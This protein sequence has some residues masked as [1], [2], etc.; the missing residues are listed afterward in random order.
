MA[1]M[2]MP[3][4]I[5]TKAGSLFN[6]IR[7]DFPEIVFE[8]SSRFSWHAGTMRVSYVLTASNEISGIWALLHELGH[9]L[10]N[11]RDFGTDIELLNK[12]VSAWEK[13]HE[14][15]HKYDLEIDQN[16]V[17]DNLDSYRDWLHLRSTCPKCHERCLQADKYTYR[18]INCHAEWKV[19]R[20]RLCRPYR[21]LRQT[22]NKSLN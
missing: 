10:L 1:V 17:E 20:S 16:Y 12:E 11:H 21:K 8:E 5:P 6:R 18:C 19:N 2:I 14:I 22:I 4:N 15:A 7:S 3:D 9:A 13:A